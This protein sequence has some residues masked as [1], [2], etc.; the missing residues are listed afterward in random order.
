MRAKATIEEVKGVN[1]LLLRNPYQ[2]NKA[3]MIKKTAELVND[4]KLEGISIFEMSP[5]EEMRI[6]Y[7]LKEMRYQTS[8][9][10]NYINT[11]HFKLHLVS[12]ILLWL[13]EDHSS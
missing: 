11:Q 9:L 2:V 5:I 6:V 13:T 4:K 1:A 10:I 3:D 8:F 7:V 12:T